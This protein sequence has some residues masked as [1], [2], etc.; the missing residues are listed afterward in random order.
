MTKI[1]DNL[2]PL[3][4]DG[5]KVMSDIATVLKDVKDPKNKSLVSKML[6]DS[7]G[8]MVAVRN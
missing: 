5:R 7:D 1:D 8:A 4:D 3:V 2:Q 6:Y